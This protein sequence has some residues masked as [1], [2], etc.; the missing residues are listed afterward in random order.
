MS[1]DSTQQLAT[2]EVLFR[3]HNERL[4]Q[5]IRHPSQLRVLDSGPAQSQYS[6]I[7]QGLSDRSRMGKLAAEIVIQT[8]YAASS[9][10]RYLSNAL[11]RY[12]ADQDNIVFE[13]TA[14]EGPFP[15]LPMD[16]RGWEGRHPTYLTYTARGENLKAFLEIVMNQKVDVKPERATLEKNTTIEERPTIKLGR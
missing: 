16:M 1:A 7:G 12:H 9:D 8:H 14:K 13:I 4:W 3:P 15:E 10:V 11:M 5:T 2:L 6:L